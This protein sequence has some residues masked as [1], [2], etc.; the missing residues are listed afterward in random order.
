MQYEKIDM[1]S[2]NLHIIKTNK[3]K[4]TTVSINFRET[5]K[6][7]DI[8]IRKFLFQMLCTNTKKYNTSRLF[9]I[10]LEDLY[11]LGLSHSNIKFGNIINSYIDIR[12]LNNK[13]S[14]NNLLNDSLDFLFEM[15]FNP[16]IKDDKF[17]SKTFDMIKNKLDL[18]IK[19]EKENIQKYTLNRALELMDSND[20]ISYN[21][22]GYKEDLDK[23]NTKN[24]YEYYK[25][26]LKTNI[27]DIF[28][29]G[30]VNKEEIISI[31]KDKFKIN[32][33]KRNTTEA[34]ITYK[35]SNKT[36]VYN[37]KMDLKQSKLAIICKLLNLS[38]YERRYVLPLYS[39]ILGG[40]ST[41]R[42]FN[43]VREKNS[44]CYTI[45]AFNNTPNSIMM[46]Y[47]GIDISNYDKALKLIKKEII[48]KN[49]TDKE[50]DNAKKEMI[51]SI[52]TLTDNVSGIIN[53]YF[54]MEVFNSDNI[55][56]KIINF[57]K[58]TINDLELL[59]KK[60]KIAMIYLL[61]GSNEKE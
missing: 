2:Y 50:L 24:L 14:D 40:S 51:T 30:D 5:L 57:N 38:L 44:L 18:I 16:N 4:S 13:Y 55:D 52:E 60:I 34:F 28:V 39:S 45:N 9:E 36:K 35:S 59:S 42:L 12:F 37:E 54:G 1:G 48:L 15:L 46:I 41:S 43:N 29:V 25:K 6:K 56:T 7:E 31:F 23:I 10:K 19:S 32:T 3:F 21:L 8:T 17:D 20:P 11:S 49:I 33:I 61:G 26:V 58:V 47:S 22:W 53:Y 27:I